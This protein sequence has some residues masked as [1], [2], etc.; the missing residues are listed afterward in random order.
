VSTGEIL[1]RV[2][3]KEQ[4]INNQLDHLTEEYKSVKAKLDTLT[5][6]YQ[7]DYYLLLYSSIHNDFMF[8]SSNTGTSENISKFTNE[9]AIITDKVEEIKVSILKDIL[10]SSTLGIYIY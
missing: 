4:Q 8:N 10:Y 3:Q 1:E 9:L 7:G 2:I 6:D 5:K